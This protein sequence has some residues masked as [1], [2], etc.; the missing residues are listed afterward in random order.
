[1]ETSDIPELLAQRIE[2]KIG[3]VIKLLQFMVFMFIF[4]YF[5]CF[6]FFKY[7]LAKINKKLESTK[8]P[9]DDNKTITK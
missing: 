3:A 1:M 2:I 9:N 4:M 8:Q 6:L 7:Q 5:S